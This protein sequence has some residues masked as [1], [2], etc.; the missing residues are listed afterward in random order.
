MQHPIRARGAKL[1]AIVLA[2][3]LGALGL[4]LGRGGSASAAS[5]DCSAGSTMIIVATK[6]TRSSS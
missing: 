2:V 5:P 1:P 3:L 4:V 6:T